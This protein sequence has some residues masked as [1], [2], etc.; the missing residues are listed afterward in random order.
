MVVL[1]E[2]EEKKKRK[3]GTVNSPYRFY[4][5]KKICIT[6]KQLKEKKETNTE[7]PEVMFYDTN[8]HYLVK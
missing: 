8:A 4:K 3:S 1:I 2:D 6:E 7:K 5:K